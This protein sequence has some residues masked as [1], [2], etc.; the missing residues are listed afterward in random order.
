MINTEHSP[1]IVLDET[2][3]RDRHVL[4]VE[5]QG[6]SRIFLYAAM[7]DDPPYSTQLGEQQITITFTKTSLIHVAT[8][9]HQLAH[10]DGAKD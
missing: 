10:N 4:G 9:L 5:A 1:L 3:I 2:V 6:L 7:Q 8:M